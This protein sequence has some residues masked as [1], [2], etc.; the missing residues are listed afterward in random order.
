MMNMSIAGRVDPY[1]DELVAIRH[2]LHAHPEIAFEEN[3]TA[4][5]VADKLREYGV[6]EVHTGIGRTGVVGVLR[7][8]GGSNRAIGLRADMDALPITE[9]T[10][11]PYRSTVE[12]KMHACGHDGH[13]TMLLGAARYLAEHRDFD[14][15]V[16]L[17]FQPAEERGGGADFMIRDGLFERFNCESVFGMHNMP[18][19]P[20]GSIAM[21]TGPI[22]AASDII[23]IVVRGTGGHGAWPHQTRDPIVAG[24]HMVTALQS[25]TSRRVDPIHAAVVSITTFRAGTGGS[26]V[27]EEIEL[28]GTC[29]S[30]LPEV[31]DL[32]EAEMKRICTEVAAAFDVTA[33]VDYA[34]GYPTTVNAPEETELAAAAARRV[35]GAQAV[36]TDVTPLMGAEDFAFMLGARP[37]TYIWL[38]TGEDRPWL[39]APDFDFND[40]AIPAGI[41]YWV[42][43]VETVLPRPD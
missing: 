43:L 22:M 8:N 16:H 4:A 21:C 17:I 31:R 42:S 24:A 41:G 36:E 37:G 32:V 29:R 3:R 30:F 11:V 14:G 1:L 34:R 38:G 20:F 7:G 19:R 6:D 15:T 28:G 26:V 40:A 13:T 10:D 18:G 9:K 23:R 12:G 25:I 39:H 33:E 27:P 5:L 2:D 35:V